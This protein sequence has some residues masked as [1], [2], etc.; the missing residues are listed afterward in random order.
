MTS[1]ASRHGRIVSAT[2]SGNEMGWTNL[3]ADLSQMNSLSPRP[4]QQSLFMYRDHRTGDWKGSTDFIR[5]VTFIVESMGT[6][7][8]EV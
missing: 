4:L 7:W 5:I 8:A 2:S 1:A 3:I 6:R